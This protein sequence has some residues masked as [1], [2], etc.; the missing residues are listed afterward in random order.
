MGW[1]EVADRLYGLPPEEFT[2][3]RD[4]AAKAAPRGQAAKIRA[5]RRPTLAAWT[6][7]LLVRSE[8]ERIETLTGLGEQLRRAHEQLD[9]RQLRELAQQ[10]RQLVAALSRRAQELAAEAGR[11]VGESVLREVEST[12]HAALADP[13]AAAE[14]TTGRL[15]KALSRPTGFGPL[16]AAAE[17]PPE[18][19]ATGASRASG[20]TGATG[21]TVSR[22]RPRKTPPTGGTKTSD[23]DRDRRAS[24]TP[25][26]RRAEEEK[27]AADRRR[28]TEETPKRP[29]AREHAEARGGS[30]AGKQ[31][32][33]RK[34]TEREQPRRGRPGN[35]ATPQQA[36]HEPDPE[37]AQ[38]A[39]A[40]KGVERERA[41]REAERERTRRA[42]VEHA[43]Q[44]RARRQAERE[45]RG[46]LREARAEAAEL[47]R[48]ARAAEAEA[49]TGE[50]ELAD[51][52]SQRQEVESLVQELADAL[53]GARTELSEAKK[54]ERA[55]R[56]RARKAREAAERDRTRAAEAAERVETFA[57]R[58]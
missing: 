45:W 23:R 12:V 33:T 10:Q 28:R 25:L 42:R 36:Q 51:A 56:T 52:E 15:S 44:E 27:A 32:E 6:A 38:R 31:A 9:G 29:A 11:P 30:E 55:A 5:L 26:H 20:T 57:V 3:A 43:E 54:T 14:L 34:R 1:E 17:P 49:A 24:V 48:A 50:R 58:G 13:D 19:G 16:T 2:T 18:G 7:N 35:A 46:A 39:T 4:E 53:R 37:P 22:I 47:R 8:P 41:Q 40:R 21:A